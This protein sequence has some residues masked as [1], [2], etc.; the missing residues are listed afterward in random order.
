MSEGLMQE[1]GA[2]IPIFFSEPVENTFRTKQEGRAQYDEVEFVRILIPGDRNTSPVQ[3]VD[4]EARARWPKEY[5]AFKAGL[6]PPLHGMPLTEWPP[7]K[8][9]QVLEFAHFHIKTVEQLA[10]VNDAQLQ[11]LGMGA[12]DL[13]EQAK[14]YL[15]IAQHGTAPIAKMVE[16]IEALTA[17]STRKDN[18][19][20]DM[21][22][23]LAALEGK[24]N[25]SDNP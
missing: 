9:S 25:A 17:E 16:Q 14:A 8:R 13:R 3:R 10:A 5:E 6:E 23:R 18:V 12:R 7:I 11:N 2:S 19:I 4:D 1:K 22:A 15:D 21:G 24:K 20:A